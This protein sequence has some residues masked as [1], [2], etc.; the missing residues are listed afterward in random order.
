MLKENS[1]LTVRIEF[2][3][4]KKRKNNKKG[5]LRESITRARGKPRTGLVKE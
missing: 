2:F 3:V 5:E 1:I 4:Q